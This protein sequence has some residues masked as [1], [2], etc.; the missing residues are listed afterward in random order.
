MCGIELTKGKD[1]VIT[2]TLVF[3]PMLQS[4]SREIHQRRYFEIIVFHSCVFTVYFKEFNS[5]LESY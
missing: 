3:F 1:V 4:E 5:I 2:L